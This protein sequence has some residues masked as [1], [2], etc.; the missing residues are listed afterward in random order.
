LVDPRRSQRLVFVERHKG[1]IGHENRIRN[2]AA[3]LGGADAS[4]DVG[5]EQRF[6]AG[7]L[8]NARVKY[9]HPRADTFRRNKVGFFARS[10]SVAMTAITIARIRNFERHDQRPPLKPIHGGLPYDQT[11]FDERRTFHGGTIY[12]GFCA[13]II[14]PSS[15]GIKLTRVYRRAR[16]HCTTKTFSTR[17]RSSAGVTSTSMNKESNG[18]RKE[19][20]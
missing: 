7:Y 6:A 11:R 5:S 17:L 19:S 16:R 12:G 1:P 10:A 18:R 13:G 20:T 9:L 4:L 3:P 15:G 14:T 8:D 2:A